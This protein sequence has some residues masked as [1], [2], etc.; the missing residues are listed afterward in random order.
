[1]EQKIIAQLECTLEMDFSTFLFDFYYKNNELEWCLPNSNITN[2]LSDT[3]KELR[4]Y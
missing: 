1:M 3:V 4:Q 2:P